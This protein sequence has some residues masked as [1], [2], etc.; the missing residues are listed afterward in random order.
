MVSDDLEDIHLNATLN[1]T[2]QT[3][4]V[5]QIIWLKFRDPNGFSVSL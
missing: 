1:E 3:W 4:F 5:L 2:D